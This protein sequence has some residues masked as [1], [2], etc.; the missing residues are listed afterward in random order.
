M[1]VVVAD[2]SVVVKWLLPER[3]GEADTGPALRLLERVVSG[4]VQLY[5]PPHWLAE[6]AAVLAR[7]SPATA[8]EDVEDLYSMEIPV[9][10]SMPVYLTACELAVD[11]EHHLFDTLYHSVALHL[12][13]ARLVT[14]DERYYR[15]AQARGRIVRLADLG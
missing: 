5:Q 9:L 15:K 3:G 8:R 14:A 2:A 7:L 13:E 11:L 12:P 4:R 10:D 6:V 1:A